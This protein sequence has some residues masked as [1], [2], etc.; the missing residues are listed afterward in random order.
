MIRATLVNTHTHTHTHTHTLY[1]YLSQQ[2]QKT[3]DAS[4]LRAAATDT[5]SS[6]KTP[7]LAVSCIQSSQHRRRDKR[8][9]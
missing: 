5:T 9:A 6:D 2:S 4:E 3:L 7:T 1:Y 8:S